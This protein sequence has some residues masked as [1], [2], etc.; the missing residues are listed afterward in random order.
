[1]QIIPITDTTIA[2]GR[3]AFDDYAAA[4]VCGPDADFHREGMARAT[5]VGVVPGIIYECLDRGCDQRQELVFAAARVSRCRRST[6]A[7]V[8]DALAGDNPELHLWQTEGVGG[9]RLLTHAS[10]RVLLAA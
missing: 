3:E 2:A 7:A 1:M 10:P 9:Y 5:G 8:L 6:V 4:A